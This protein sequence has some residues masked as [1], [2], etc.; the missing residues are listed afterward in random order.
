MARPL[1]VVE[2]KSIASESIISHV[3]NLNEKSR[4]LLTGKSLEPVLLLKSKIDFFFNS[5]S[6]QRW[7]KKFKNVMVWNQYENI[8]EK[9]RN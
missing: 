4:T 9:F 2:A 7:F 6:S 3:D 5:W 1:L 8:Q